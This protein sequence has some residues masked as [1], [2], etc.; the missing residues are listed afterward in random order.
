MTL[1]EA[2]VAAAILAV[3]ALGGLAYQYFG[4]V[5]FRIALAELT[6]TR[7]GQLLLEDWKGS[8]AP[9][10]VNYDATA[11]GIGFTTGAGSDY[12]ITVDGITMFVWLTYQDVEVDTVA[13]LTLRQISTSLAWRR[14]Y[15][16]GMPGADDPSLI[17]TT[18]AR[19]GQD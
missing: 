3:L 5:H 17:L 8:G 19:R 11:L 12:V 10:P 4:A 18:Y 14:D 15:A 6:A 13:G 2:L 7:A 1:I 9:D 16:A